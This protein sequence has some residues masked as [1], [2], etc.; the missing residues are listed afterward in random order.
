MNFKLM[1]LIANACVKWI[2]NAERED[3]IEVFGSAHL[4]NKYC[5]NYKRNEGDLICS[6]DA[7]NLEKLARVA[8]ESYVPEMLAS[9]AMI[10]QALESLQAIAEGRE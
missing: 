3:F 9:E 5:D 1:G 7:D 6:M 10:K 8:F 2:F 4:W